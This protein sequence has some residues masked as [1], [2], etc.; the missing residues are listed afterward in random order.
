MNFFFP[1]RGLLSL[2]HILDLSHRISNIRHTRT[3]RKL[4][5]PAVMAV[6]HSRSA[7][8]ARANVFQEVRSTRRRE[9]PDLVDLYF[10]LPHW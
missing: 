1:V 3:A 7:H 9:C 5:C 4:Q 6:S 10:R 2:C 8:T